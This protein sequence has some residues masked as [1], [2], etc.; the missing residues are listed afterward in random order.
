MKEERIKEL[1][2]MMY[3]INNYEVLAAAKDTIFTE[4]PDT[5]NTDKFVLRWYTE[6]AVFVRRTEYSKVIKITY[7]SD[8]W[9]LSKT[10][11]DD[12]T[13]LLDYD[14]NNHVIIEI[15]QRIVDELMQLGAK[16]IF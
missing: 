4:N 13:D 8:D 15:K 3:M 11:Y 6:F 12:Y 14:I 9:E 7:T 2:D 5:R 1:K 16:K 10:T